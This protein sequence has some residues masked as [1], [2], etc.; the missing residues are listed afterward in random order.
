MSNR[1]GAEVY[2]ELHTDGAGNRAIKALEVVAD[3]PVGKK[4][5][6]SVLRGIAKGLE[7]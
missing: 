4:E 5:M 7:A 6:A 2:F 1:N 3:A